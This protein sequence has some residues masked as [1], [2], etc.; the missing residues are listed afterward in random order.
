MQGGETLTGF[1]NDT[2][3]SGTVIYNGT[4]TYASLIAGSSYAN[5]Q[6]NGSGGTWRPASNVTVSGTVQTTL[7]TYDPSNASVTTTVTGLTTV[8]GGTYLTGTATQTFNGGFTLSSG[9]LTG[10]SG[11]FACN[12][13][14][15][16]SGGTFTQPSG[17]FT[18]SGNVTTSGA[19]TWTP[20]TGT[21]TL[22]GAG[23]TTQTLN[24]GTDPSLYSLSF[25]TGD[26][27]ILNTDGTTLTITHDITGN[28]TA[29][30]L[31][32]LGG[33]STGGWT[34]SVPS[35]QSLSYLS[36]SYGT[37]TSNTAAAGSTSTDGGG[38]VNWTFGSGGGGYTTYVIGGGLGAGTFIIGD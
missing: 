38:N 30:H 34:W 18:I 10:S 11:A 13:N 14:F 21:L 20:G 28:G 2:A 35:I 29:G 17:T 36:V 22:N 19:G 33:T 24:I 9:T 26:R 3:H 15:I 27:T 5:L 12:G 7:G 23:S 6:F 8:N 4:S 25:A 37:A 1:T 32:T 31:I 16:W